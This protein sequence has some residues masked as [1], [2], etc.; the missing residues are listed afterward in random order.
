MAYE[1]LED[2]NELTRLEAFMYQA[3]EMQKKTF[4]PP[5]A[6]KGLKVQGVINKISP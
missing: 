4:N 3:K 5:L 6:D 2:S 1:G